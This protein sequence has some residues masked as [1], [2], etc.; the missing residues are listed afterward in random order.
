MTDIHSRMQLA[1]DMFLCE[2]LLSKD[3]L[4]E[5]GYALTSLTLEMLLTNS[6]FFYPL[7]R[8]VTPYF[9]SLVMTTS[10]V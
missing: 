5:Y 2:A 9:S 3:V 1:L 7:D 6:F 10:A 4:K 8:F